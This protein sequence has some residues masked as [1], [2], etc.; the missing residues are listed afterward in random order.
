MQAVAGAG[1]GGPLVAIAAGQ[2]QGIGAFG[3]CGR[4]I[5][6]NRQRTDAAGKPGTGVERSRKVVGYQ[7]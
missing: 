3:G 2:T 1:D 6:Q 4:L 5:Q 7:A